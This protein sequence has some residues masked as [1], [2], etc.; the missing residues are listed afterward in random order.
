MN[1]RPYQTDMMDRVSIALRTN[2]RVLLESP[3]G[4]GKTLLA[5][6]MV[7]GAATKGRRI[8]WL[9]HRTEL[10]AQTS[11][12]FDALGID[13]GF[14]AAGMPFNRH[15]SVYIGSI[16]SV[17]SR[18]EGLQPFDLLIADEAH[19]S[20]SKTW[21]HVIE[22][23]NPRWVIGLSATPCRL[24]G[25]GL[26]ENFD[27]IVHGEPVASLIAGGFL[28]PFKVYAP[29][30]IDL[31][32]VRT[33]A[34]DYNAADVA[35]A[36][37]KPVITGSAVE[38]YQRITPGAR[39]V[40]FCTSVKHAEHVAAA[41]IEAG[42]AARS[43]DGTMSRDERANVIGDFERGATL[44][45]TSCDLVSEGFD[46]PGIEC[47]I[48]LRP[49]KSLSLWL[50]QVGRALR[51][52]PGK[53]A[54]IL[55]HAGNTDRHGFPDDPREWT[56]DARAKRKR[57][58]ALAIKTCKV[59]FTVY[60]PARVCPGCGLEVETVS[61]E[62]EHVEGQLVEAQRKLPTADKAQF[63]AELLGY[64]EDRDKQPKY[65]LALFHN[66]FGHWPHAKNSIEAVEPSEQTLAYIRERNREYA[67]RIAAEN[68]LRSGELVSA[69]AVA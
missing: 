40:V 22:T 57:E 68:A 60:R 26:G 55:D 1:L 39:A 34:G 56:L 37:D 21:Q 59:C 43:I 11:R 42:I 51:F 25:R 45:L 53:T 32:G 33:T 12:T 63:Y 10:I 47:A 6:T 24:D 8:I 27:A 41:F 15:K 54:V 3:T 49:T 46:V 18:L 64:C 7:N 65:A 16:G 9:A 48:S 50:Q 5:S 14:M 20:V 19:R 52:V 36:A 69:G 13:H 4:S 58:A 31:T 17:A 23:I 62:L 35:A 30:V 38:H 67:K 29:S 66:R 44:V 2:R 61:R 28:A